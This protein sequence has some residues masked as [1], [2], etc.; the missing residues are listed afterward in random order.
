MA[1][2]VQNKTLHFLLRIANHPQS[3]ILTFVVTIFAGTVVYWLLEP[4]TLVQSLEW[5][6]QTATSTGYGNYSSTTVLG[7]LF[8]SLFMLWGVAIILTLITGSVV[9]A[10]R[11]DP[12]VFTDEEQKEILSYVRDQ[13]KKEDILDTVYDESPDDG[14]TYVD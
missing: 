11:V 13:R 10:L 2:A 14:V 1:K 3:L 4:Y 6:V 5:A 12:N 7:S 8:S 9:N